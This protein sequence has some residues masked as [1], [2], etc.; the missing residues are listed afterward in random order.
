MHATM[1][2]KQNIA[3]MKYGIF[4]VFKNK[5]EN[6]KEFVLA[7]SPLLE[8][9]EKEWTSKDGVRYIYLDCIGPKRDM[10]L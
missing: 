8:I 4:K 9:T 10:L 1:M 6:L 3:R 7:G 2:Y 5:Y